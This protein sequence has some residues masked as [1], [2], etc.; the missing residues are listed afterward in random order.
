MNMKKEILKTVEAYLDTNRDFISNEE[1]ESLKMQILALQIEIRKEEQSEYL[2]QLKAF[3][4]H[5]ENTF[6]V[7]MDDSATDADVE[8]FY[9]SDFTLTFR[10][11]SITLYNGGEMW[12]GI[13]GII[14][15]EIDDN[16]V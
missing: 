3:R 10:G 12:N 8:L 13:E 14:Q 11:K 4:N 1:I 5:M 7:L 2:K 15:A 6:E 9:N 16:E